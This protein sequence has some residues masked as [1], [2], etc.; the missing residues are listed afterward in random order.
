M[1]LGAYLGVVTLHKLLA[2]YDGAILRG[3]APKHRL[4]GCSTLSLGIYC[5]SA[6]LIYTLRATVAHAD[7]GVCFEEVD[8][9]LQLLAVSEVV[10][11]IQ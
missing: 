10:V 11:A 1:L 3:I 4:K 9:H 7:I 5:R 2:R 8:L 6:I